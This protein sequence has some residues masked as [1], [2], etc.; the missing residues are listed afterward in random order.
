M[1]LKNGFLV[2]GAA[3]KTWWDDWANQVLVSLAAMLLSLT[4]VFYPAA[5]F[6]IFQES[7]D[8]THGI[9]TGIAGWWQGVKQ[10][11]GK[12]L[13]WGLI[14][15]LV[16][17]GMAFS[18]WFYVQSELAIAIYLVAFLG[19]LWL[20]WFFWQFYALACFFLQEDRQLKLAWQ[21]GLAILATNLALC[22]FPGILSAALLVVSLRF[23][24]PLAVGIPTLV[25]IIA[26]MTVQKS[27]KTEKQTGEG[28][29]R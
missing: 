22:L 7:L 1:D 11:L 24:I 18:I 9:R 27:L 19:L 13:V 4:I 6:G 29:N 3:F 16:T 12:S 25:A 10:N 14:N 23:F 26:L 8:L 2:I 15:T 21:N 5:I 20:F 17:V 28:T